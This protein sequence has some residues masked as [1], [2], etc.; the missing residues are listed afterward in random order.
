MKRRARLVMDLAVVLA[1]DDDLARQDA[2]WRRRG[3]ERSSCRVWRCGDGSFTARLVW[4]NRQA[5]VSTITCVMRGL[6]LPMAGA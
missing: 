5:T 3:Y 1:M 4:R 6:R 2:T